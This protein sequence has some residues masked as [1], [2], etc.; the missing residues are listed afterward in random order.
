MRSTGRLAL[1]LLAALCV[2]AL[3]AGYGLDHAPRENVPGWLGILAVSAGVL[4]LGAWGAARLEPR[5]FMVVLFG[6]A[7]A[8]RAATLLAPISLS[9]DVYRYLWDGTLV[10]DGQNPFLSRPFEVVGTAPHL[11]REALGRMNSPR[12]YSVYPPLSQAVFAL[13]ATLQPWG[14]R[15]LRLLFALADL[16][17][18]W[19]LLG[20]LRRL[21]RHPA[22]VFLYAWN[23]L[24]YWEVAAGGHT[25]AL[26]VPFLLVG[27]SA[28]LD[29]RSGRAGASLALAAAAK[30]TA[31]VLAPL[32]LVYIGRS[33]V[34]KERYRRPAAFVISLAALFTACFVPF[35]DPVL[36]PHMRES[37][38]LYSEVFSF[39]APVYYAMRHGMGYI[40]GI[41]PTV[42]STLMPGLVAAT[43]FWLALMSLVQNGSRE[44]FVGGLAFAFLGYLVFSRV[45]HPWYLLP[46]LALG[47]AARS[48][49]IL[50]LGLLVPLSYLRY[51][52]FDREEPWVLVVQFLPVLFVLLAEGAQRIGGLDVLW[53]WGQREAQTPVSAIDSV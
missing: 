45:V 21:G 8:L 15:A 7:I 2:A 32:F 29:G 16:A 41:T 3:T 42:D 23:P 9:D 5:S 18:I 31:L 33:A 27:L 36:W 39:N 25:E 30:F 53:R 40:E 24:V 13:A 22:W 50:L 44:R 1:P 6:G 35:Y 17:A 12:Y 37:L 43:L 38:S 19:A 20:V 11:D 10:A 49:S 47:A 26:M 4:A 34:E 52:P 14:E 28:A 48:P 51:S 46:L